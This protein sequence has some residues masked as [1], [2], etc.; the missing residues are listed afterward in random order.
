MSSSC[1]VGAFA[2]SGFREAGFVLLNPHR[3]V[4]SVK[5]HC[6]FS[7]RAVT[8]GDVLQMFEQECG[9]IYYEDCAIA[10]NARR[11]LCR[12]TTACSEPP[13]ECLHSNWSWGYAVD[14]CCSAHA[15]E[16][17]DEQIP[18]PF[19]RAYLLAQ[20][21]AQENLN[22]TSA[23]T[24]RTDLYAVNELIIK[25]TT[26]WPG[27]DPPGVSMSEHWHEGGLAVVYFI[28]HFWGEDFGE[29]VQSLFRFALLE[30]NDPNLTKKAI[31]QKAKQL[32]LYICAFSNNQHNIEEELSGDIRQSPFYVALTSPTTTKVVL[33]L[34]TQIAA[35]QRAWCAFEF[36]L[37][38]MEKKDF[39]LNTYIGPLNRLPLESQEE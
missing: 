11:M 36:S 17:A 3:C 8:V 35:L 26:A 5:A 20:R 34:D 15:A 14:G 30:V 19:C 9:V 38:V 27:C 22:Q 33:N 6:D 37:T 7:M 2:D 32:Q 18:K 16:D 12:M 13:D 23:H 24:L 21:V 29:F 4:A 31:I 1:Y 25:P 10:I 28:S 39:V